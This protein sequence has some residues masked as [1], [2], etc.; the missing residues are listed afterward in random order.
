MTSESFESVQF[1]PP[2]QPN[3]PFLPPY[4]NLVWINTISEW[5][6]R[7]GGGG[8]GCTHTVHL[9]QDEVTTPP[10]YSHTQ[11]EGSKCNTSKVCAHSLTVHPLVW[12][13]PQNTATRSRRGQSSAGTCWSY[14]QWGQKVKTKLLSETVSAKNINHPKP[15]TL[16]LVYT[17][18]LIQILI[19]TGCVYTEANWIQIQTQTTSPMWIVIQIRIRIRD[20]VLV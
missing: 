5:G 20:L 13:H 18:I 3:P 14:L 2:S 8:G 6:G 10:E 16:S 15:I 4:P 1:T 7:G 11:Q 12:P 19:Q 17:G 9:N